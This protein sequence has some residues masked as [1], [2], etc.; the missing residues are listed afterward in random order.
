MGGSADT[1]FAVVFLCTFLV[2][3]LAFEAVARRWSRPAVTGEVLMP[4]LSLDEAKSQALAILGDSSRFRCVEEPIPRDAGPVEML[5]TELN[6]FFG[7]YREVRMVYGDMVLDRDGIR[8]SEIDQQF[9]KVGRDTEHAE[10]A[11][12]RGSDVV[13]EID[14]SS[15]GGAPLA[16]YPSVYHLILDRNHVIH[17]DG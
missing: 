3:S 13:L 14:E 16:E 9:F 8:P 10:L 15:R 4:D 12:R 1:R 5:G 6:A 2:L 7:R 11:V 17:G